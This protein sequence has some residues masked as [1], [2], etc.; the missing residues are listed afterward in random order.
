MRDTEC[1]ALLQWALPR[2]RRRWPGFRKV[3]GQVCKRVAR[4]MRQLGLA[5]PEDYH[6]YI[7]DHP[8]EWAELDRLCAIT[9][10][11]FYRDKA[12]F[13]F[14]GQTVL[15]NLAQSAEDTGLRAWSIGCASGEEPYSLMLA[16]HFAAQQFFPVMRLDILATDVEEPVLI[17]ARAACYSIGS[18]RQLP[19]TWLEQAFTRINS[20][21]CLNIAYRKGI[22]FQLQD[23][24]SALPE[25]DFHI[26]LC[27]NLAFTYFDETL[28]KESIDRIVSR[29][30][31]GG[32]LVTGR[33]ETL[34][35][36]TPGLTPW[37]GAEKLGIYRLGPP[38]RHE[39]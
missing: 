38:D 15:G 37:P 8:E 27:R 29:L 2:L 6:R 23:L 33:R 10:S 26:I 30:R 13:D 32:A 20:H 4:R 11:S 1:V 18:L 24:R 17:R 25:K 16:W 22:D 36:G 3:R 7:G 31:P 28:Q 21:Y 14:L 5:G 9:I 12:V 34:P 35:P 39:V 19:E